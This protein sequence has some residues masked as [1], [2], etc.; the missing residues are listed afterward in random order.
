MD[1]AT[2]PAGTRITVVGES[3]GTVREKLDEMDYSYPIVE[4]E[5]IKVWPNRPPEWDRPY[6]YPYG[7]L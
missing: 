4:S 5:Y 7:I 6:P 1:P 3:K 2:I